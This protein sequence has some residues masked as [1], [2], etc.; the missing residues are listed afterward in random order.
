MS[1][2]L[3]VVGWEVGYA[4]HQV[5]HE[6]LAGTH[7]FKPLGQRSIRIFLDVDFGFDGHRSPATRGVDGHLL[8]LGAGETQAMSGGWATGRLKGTEDADF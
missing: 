5:G 8:N 4:F 6:H 7:G 1:I 3:G 2:T